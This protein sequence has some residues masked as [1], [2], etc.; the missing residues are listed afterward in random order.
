MSKVYVGS[1]N[2]AK[3]AA[4]KS[5]FNEYEVIAIKTN[6]GVSNQPIGDPE[7]I[8]GA[9]NRSLSLPTNGLRIGLEGGI[10]LQDETLFLINW[11]VL[12][13]SD[14]NIYYAG[15]TRIPLP[16]DFK[17]LLTNRNLELADLIDEYAHKTNVRSNEGAIG[18]LTNNLV[19]R[20][21]IFTH[22]CKLLYG[23]YLHHKG[24]K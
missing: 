14:D 23:Q 8:E 10:M 16:N 17:I 21:D 20:T 9:K 3:V 22:I 4:V 15:G 19:I 18:I 7:T 12:I 13:D 11:G 6:S 1:T 2:P 5:V 24:G